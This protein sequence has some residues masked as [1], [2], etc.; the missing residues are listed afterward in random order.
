MF[1]TIVVSVLIGGVVGFI[2]GK[3]HTDNETTVRLRKRG[4]VIHYTERYYD[5]SGYKFIYN[6]FDDN[7]K[8]VCVKGPEFAKHVDAVANADA[9]YIANIT[10]G[11]TLTGV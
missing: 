4:Y 2:I 3:M 5:P 9:H 6:G 10:K 11:Q 1:I 7:L 8:P